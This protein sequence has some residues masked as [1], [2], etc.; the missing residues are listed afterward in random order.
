MRRTIKLFCPNCI[1]YT[2]LETFS[3]HRVLLVTCG[4]CGNVYQIDTLKNEKMKL[5]KDEEKAR[6]LM[7][8]E[9]GDGMI[10]D[11]TKATITGDAEVVES[12]YGERIVIGVTLKS[13]ERR[14]WSLNP[15]AKNYLIDK[16]GS[17]S[18]GWIGKEIQI[19]IDA[20]DLVDKETKE[21]YKQKYLM[22][23][24]A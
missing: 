18:R 7:V 17:E 9:I 5:T 23:Y 4:F 16:L 13:G 11:R 22:P 19:Y 8:S 14:L 12:E 21:R 1:K 24:I 10:E 15:T 3:E 2:Y 20:I 6:Y